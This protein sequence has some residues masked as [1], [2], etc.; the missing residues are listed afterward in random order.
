MRRWV[1]KRFHDDFGTVE[2]TSA[3]FSLTDG[4]IL[5][6]PSLQTFLALTLPAGFSD[7]NHYYPLPSELETFFATCATRWDDE[8]T[9]I[10]RE[11][12]ESKIRILSSFATVLSEAVTKSSV[13]EGLEEALSIAN[14]GSY[15][16]EEQIES[17]LEELDTIYALFSC[18]EGTPLISEL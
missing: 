7:P 15:S 8:K 12:G 9:S 4:E 3:P 13:R 18:S 17:L 2:D 5:V 11:A 10:Q 16:Q 14:D 6:L 1:L